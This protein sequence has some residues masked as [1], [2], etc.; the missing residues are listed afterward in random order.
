MRKVFFLVLL[1]IS[2]NLYGQQAESIADQYAAHLGGYA[3]FKKI[4]TAKMTCRTIMD[5][6]EFPSLIIVETGK[7]IY[8]EI[9]I[10][11]KKFISG[12]DHGKAWTSDFRLGPDTIRDMNMQETLEQKTLT[13]MG[14]PLIE[15]RENGT[16]LGYGGIRKVREKETYR[17]DLYDSTG[18]ITEKFYIDT[19]TYMP[20]QV[21]HFKY[22]D[23]KTIELQ[24]V[25]SDP[26][27]FN[28]VVFFMKQDMYK[29]GALV[30][31]LTF[32]KVEL[33]LPVDRKVFQKPATTH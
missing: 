11:D 25:V 24:L 12:Y 1:T 33:N 9:S 10:M 18:N 2:A 3:G 5:G 16:K 14:G 4:K 19:A 13:S 20:I 17:I 26:K 27:R 22:E 28:G 8:S 21:S 31:T 30:Q 6:Q 29:E 15:Y 32:D 23:G 7:A